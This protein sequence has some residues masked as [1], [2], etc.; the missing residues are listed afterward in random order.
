MEWASGTSQANHPF[1]LEENP[2]VESQTTPVEEN[3]ETSDDSN[4]NINDIINSFNLVIEWTKENNLPC[5]E[6]LLLQRI[7]KKAIMNKYI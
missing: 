2:K 4:K 1:N 7:R 3:E 6:D 5:T